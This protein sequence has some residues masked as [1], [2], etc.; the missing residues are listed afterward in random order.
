MHVVEPPR[1]RSVAADL[2]RAKLI[3]AQLSI[4]LIIQKIFIEP[5]IVHIPPD[6]VHV[7]NFIFRIEQSLPRV[8][9]GRRSR[10]AGVFPLGLRRQV[11]FQPRQL[12]Q[13]AHEGEII[14]LVGIRPA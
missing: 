5:A 12:P 4:S 1:I 7:F 11:E 13:E 9:G 8:Q 2:R 3:H 10:A 6:G 14:D